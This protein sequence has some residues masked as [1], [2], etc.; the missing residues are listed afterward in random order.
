MTVSA[1]AKDG[2]KFLRWSDGSTDGTSHEVAIGSSP[3]TLTAVFYKAGDRKVPVTLLSNPAGASLSIG[4]DSGCTNAAPVWLCP[5]GSITVTAPATSSGS[6]VRSWS[7]GLICGTPGCTDK[8]TVGT[9]PV[10]LIAN[11]D[12]SGVP[13]S[14]TTD[15]PGLWFSVNGISTNSPL[16]ASFRAGS[17][18]ALNTA[19]AQSL[20]GLQYAF[21]GWNDGG[22]GGAN[23]GSS[24][25]TAHLYPIPTNS[26]SVLLTAVFTPSSPGPTEQSLALLN[27]TYPQVHSLSR[28]NIATGIVYSWLRSPSWTRQET[29]PAVTCPTGAPQPCIP[30]PALYQTVENPPSTHTIDP[31]LFFMVYLHRLDSERKWHFKDL[32]PAANIGLSL[33]SPATD[34][35]LGGS[36]ELVVRGLQVTGGVHIGKVAELAPSGVNDPT[37]SA[38]PAT[39]ERFHKAAFVGVTFN[40]NFI[41]TLFSA[42]K[43]GG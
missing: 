12:A 34:F 23:S 9:E 5:Q 18:I 15:P 24:A 38:T 13:V 14:I 17:S 35:F 37:S 39:I 30:S 2:Y 41:Q 4:A 36:T 19:A 1:T 21:S 43:G 8:V 29:S 27:T 42:A 40:I 26:P 25:S 10:T 6:N 3:I 22:S 7:N 28:F 20:D 16:V 32:I 33:S 31:V 11:Y